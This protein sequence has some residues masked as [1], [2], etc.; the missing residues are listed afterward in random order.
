MIAS[1]DRS[2]WTWIVTMTDGQQIDFQSVFGVPSADY[3]RGFE[4]LPA[5]F[6]RKVTRD[7]IVTFLSR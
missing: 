2:G 3:G 7:A 4:R 6:G 1:I 5:E